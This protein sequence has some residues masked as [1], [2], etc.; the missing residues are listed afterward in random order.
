MQLLAD[1]FATALPLAEIGLRLVA[2]AVLGALLGVER[3]WRERPAGLR[4]HILVCVAS[5]S[6]ALIAIEMINEPKFSGDSLRI[7]PLRLIEAITGGVAFLAAGFIVFFKG[8]V[9]GVTTGAGM[10]LAA[11]V[12]LAAGLG[13][14]TI[15]AL[16]TLIGF[17]VLAMVR[18]VE[19][20]F[21]WKEKLDDKEDAG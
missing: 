8:E 1:H 21:D 20:R 15:A 9:H 3:E 12:G 13:M 5:A 18:R 7:D 10:W 14:F 6:F 11:A 4:T 19:V 17:C 2:A 16:A